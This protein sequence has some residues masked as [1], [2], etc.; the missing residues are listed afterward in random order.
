MGPGSK[1]IFPENHEYNWPWA[2]LA[3]GCFNGR[4][5]FWPGLSSKHPVFGFLLYRFCSQPFSFASLLLPDMEE[6]KDVELRI[7]CIVTFMNPSS[8][9]FAVIQIPRSKLTI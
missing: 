2:F 8:A 4:I 5:I 1:K 6:M 7:I 9:L 3:D